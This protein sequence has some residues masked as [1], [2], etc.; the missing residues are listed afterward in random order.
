MQHEGGMASRARAARRATHTK[1]VPATDVTSPRTPVT[2]P[3]AAAGP[4]SKMVPSCASALELCEKACVAT[5]SN[6]MSADT[7]RQPDPVARW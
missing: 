4:E 6:H 7:A 3:S 5:K 2:A 1:K